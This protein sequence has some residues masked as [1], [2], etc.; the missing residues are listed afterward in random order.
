VEK[1]TFA[2]SAYIGVEA[3]TA[4][5][6]VADLRKL[7]EWTL[8]SRMKE[9]VDENT[10][11]GTASGYH[12]PLYYHIR[13]FAELPFLGFEWQCGLEY[14]QYYHVYPVFLF[15]SEYIEP[16][17]TENGVYFHWISFVGPKRRT[18]LI[19][20]GID[21]VHTSETRA[22]K[23][24]LERT[25]GLRSPAQ[26]RYRLKT[27]TIYV[28]APFALL[29]D[30]LTDLTY[31]TDWGHLLRA[32]GTVSPDQGTFLDEYDHPLDIRT[33]AYNFSDSCMIESDASYQH[34]NRRVRT[35]SL[36]VPCS[37]A[38]GEPSAR[39]CI[40]HRL[41]FVPVDEAQAAQHPRDDIAAE[42]LNIKRLTEAQA[43]NVASLARGFSYVEPEE[44]RAP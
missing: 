10:W 38:F 6:Y 7:D 34:S 30:Y 39:G 11:I 28:D 37:H 43:G 42:N 17:T 2:T 4:Y 13:E 40:L 27:H 5:R 35:V 21:I 23:A 16:G 9:Q 29:T 36:I 31:M 1:N 44:N 24:V 32:Q 18:P 22:L 19:M 33:R 26:G 12:Q 15:P 20:E 8:Y 41:T 14:K 3:N 25:A